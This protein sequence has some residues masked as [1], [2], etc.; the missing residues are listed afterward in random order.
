MIISTREHYCL[1]VC[2]H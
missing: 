1:L 2:E